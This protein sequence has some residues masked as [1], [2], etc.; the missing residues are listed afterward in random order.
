MSELTTLEV[1]SN[2]ECD[3]PPALYLCDTTFYNAKAEQVR[4]LLK[5]AGGNYMV[6]WWVTEHEDAMFLK[7]S[8]SD[9]DEIVATV[10]EIP[11][12]EFNLDDEDLRLDG[13]CLKIYADGAIQIVWQLK[14]SSEEMWV[15]IK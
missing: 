6:F 2:I 15:D 11:Y 9:D 1:F 13:T 3:T 10:D 8:D 12:T 7:E 4:A 5:E 14:Y